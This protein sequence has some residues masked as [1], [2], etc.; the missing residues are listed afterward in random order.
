MRNTIGHQG[1]NERQ[2]KKNQQEHVRYFL[3]EKCNQE[4]WTFHVAVVQ[5]NGKM[6]K[7][8]ALHVQS[9][10]FM[11]NRPIVVFSPFSLASPLIIILFGQ[12][13]KYYRELRFSPWLNLYII[14][15][16]R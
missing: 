16:K 14:C 13:L 5:N 15:T 9:F 10:F 11:L 8:S 3:H 12:T 7:N 6:Y 2:W 1:E 4:E